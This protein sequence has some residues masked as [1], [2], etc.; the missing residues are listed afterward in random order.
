MHDVDR[1]GNSGFG[2]RMD[3]T[4]V[5]KSD[6]WQQNGPHAFLATFTGNN[7]GAPQN[8]NRRVAQSINPKTYLGVICPL[9]A[10]TGELLYG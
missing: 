4:G 8:N 2:S 5:H 3:S 7:P 9:I 6:R 1:F 10:T